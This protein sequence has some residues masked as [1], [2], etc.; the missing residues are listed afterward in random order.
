MNYIM[1]AG[2][3]GSDAEERMTQSGAKVVSFRVA[4]NG[5]KNTTTTWW[6]VSV[7]GDRY[8]K[9]VPYL[10]KGS[11]VIVHGEMSPPETYTAKDG[12][13]QISL[14]VTANS[15]SFSPFGKGDRSQSQQGSDQSQSNQDFPNPYSAPNTAS[16][17]SYNTYQQPSQGSQ[18]SMPDFGD[19]EI[20]F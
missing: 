12:S 17:N 9:M 10:R 18:D 4:V 7:W 15:I 19:E 6:K 8:D 2:H 3:L 13:T 20:P 1:I 14:A 5:K 16:Q 11:G